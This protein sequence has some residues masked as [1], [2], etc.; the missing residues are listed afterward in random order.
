MTTGVEDRQLSAASAHTLADSAGGLRELIA[1]AVGAACAPADSEDSMDSEGSEDSM[2]V[3]S[4]GV[5]ANL[6][7]D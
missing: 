5:G 6:R 4:M 2:A 1:L 3:G 7:E